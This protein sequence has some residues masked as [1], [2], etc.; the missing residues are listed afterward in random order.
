[1]RIV[2]C[3]LGG[4]LSFE[5]GKAILEVA[6]DHI[7]RNNP[8]GGD[9]GVALGQDFKPTGWRYGRGR[10]VVHMRDNRR[11]QAGVPVL[12]RAADTS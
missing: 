2:T 12:I 8:A 5:P 9:V 10:S 6:Q 7:A 3:P 11:Y 1:V 4:G